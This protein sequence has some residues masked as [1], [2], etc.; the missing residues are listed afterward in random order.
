MTWPTKKP[1]SG[2][3]AR[4]P[5]IGGPSSGKA[6]QAFTDTNQPSGEEKSAGHAVAREVRELIAEK[7]HALVDKLLALSERGETHSVQL[8]ATNAALDRLMGKPAQAVTGED[9]GP[10]RMVVAWEDET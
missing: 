7:R 9:G 8:Q 10:V 1:P 5:G 4:G 2:I 6:A 3:P